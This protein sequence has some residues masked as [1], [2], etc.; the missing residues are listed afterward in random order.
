MER[1]FLLHCEHCG[2]RELRGPRS[3]STT[4]IGEFVATCRSCGAMAHVAGGHQHAAAPA[5]PEPVAS[6]A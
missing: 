4:D 2:R 1:M 3:L 6:A 5:Q